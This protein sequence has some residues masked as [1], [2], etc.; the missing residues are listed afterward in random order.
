MQVQQDSS[1]D[2]NADAAQTIQALQQKIDELTTTNLA[3]QE[4][5]AR[6]EQFTAMIAHELR[7]PL[8]SIIS[9][10]QILIRT[11]GKTG[12][13][14]KT[15]DNGRQRANSLQRASNVI[16]SQGRR[17]A[18]L[19]NDL[20]DSSN[21]TSGKF[22]LVRNTCNIATVV[23]EMVELMRPVAPYH[24]LVMDAQT[25]TIIG[26]FDSERIQ[27]V[28]GN[29]LDNAI[30]YSDE[31]TTITVRVWTTPDKVHVSVHNQGT[32]IPSAEIGLLFQPYSRLSAATMGTRRGVG[33]GLHTARSIIEAHG[34][35]LHLEPHID[36]KQAEGPKGTTFTFTLPLS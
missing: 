27:Q 26:N 16:F 22:T 20:L 11:N 18:R 36:E 31:H 29:L 21:L 19:V 3:L 6:K 34:G 25:A 28:L 33:L 5:L 8:T 2:S 10:A 17:L 14:G 32:S 30:K 9:Y 13:N 24:T 7:N 23:S 12:E 1:Q 15:H 4:Q 35:E